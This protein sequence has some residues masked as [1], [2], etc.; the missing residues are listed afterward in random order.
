MSIAFSNIT[1][2]GGLGEAA[3]LMSLYMN[4]IYGN[5]NSDCKQFYLDSKGE[6]Q[7]R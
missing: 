5:N 4:E 6:T 7:I 3:T 2:T 1:S